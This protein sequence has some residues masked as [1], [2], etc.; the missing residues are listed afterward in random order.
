MNTL[1]ATEENMLAI[2]LPRKYLIHPCTTYDRIV[3][4]V[5]RDI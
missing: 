2:T 4:R 1:R 3:T 5:R